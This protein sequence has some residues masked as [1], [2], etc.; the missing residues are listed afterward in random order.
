MPRHPPRTPWRGSAP[1]GSELQDKG[2]GGKAFRAERAG[3]S[4]QEKLKGSPG[5][6]LLE[7]EVPVAKGQVVARPGVASIAVW[8]A[9]ARAGCLRGSGSEHREH[10]DSNMRAASLSP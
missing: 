1:E 3:A 2:K 10:I 8:R 6:P 9:P 5:E 7:A 4:R